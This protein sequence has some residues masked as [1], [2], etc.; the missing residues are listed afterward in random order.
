MNYRQYCLLK[1]KKAQCESCE[2]SFIWVSE[3]CSL[4]G[5]TS[6]SFENLLQ[7]G[8]GEDSIYVILVKR[9]YMQSSMFIFYKV[10]AGLMKFLQVTRNCCHHEVF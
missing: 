7:R 2:L 5:S 1:K 3:D 9:E 4:G 10:S 8:K 6:D